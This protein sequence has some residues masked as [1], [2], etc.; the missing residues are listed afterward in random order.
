MTG[1]TPSSTIVFLPRDNLLETRVMIH[2]GPC[3]SVALFFG[4][5]NATTHW[6]STKREANRVAAKLLGRASLRGAT[7]RPAE[8]GTVYQFN[9]VSRVVINDMRIPSE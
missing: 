7:S 9:D 1:L 5:V 2:F 6:V 8:H 3:I 4:E